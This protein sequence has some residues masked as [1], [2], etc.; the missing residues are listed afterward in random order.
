MF[1]IPF[2]SN[3]C[4][5]LIRLATLLGKFALL[6]SLTYY[7]PASDVGLYG[8]MVAISAY[9]TFFIG[10]E[11]YN[12]VQRIIVD[13]APGDQKELFRTNLYYMFLFSLL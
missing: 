5:M 11:Y 8:L 3:I 7:L 2:I 6:I 4:A 10:F 12:Y 9:A 13:C 1:N